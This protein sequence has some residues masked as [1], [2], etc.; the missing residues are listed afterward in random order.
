[1]SSRRNGKVK[2]FEASKGFG[3]ITD[4]NGQDLFVHF[5]DIQAEGYKT[6]S[7]GEEVSFEIEMAE[8]GEKA[9]SVEKI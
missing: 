7:E 9:V 1:M 5:S 3:F 4:E 2:W 6:L 8:K